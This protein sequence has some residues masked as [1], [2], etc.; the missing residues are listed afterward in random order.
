MFLYK[1]T[2]GNMGENAGNELE[3]NHFTQ[4][5]CVFKILLNGMLFVILVTCSQ[6]PFVAKFFREEEQSAVSSKSI[7]VRPAR[8]GVKPT[9]K[10]LRTSVGDKVSCLL[11]HCSLADT[12]SNSPQFAVCKKT[13]RLY[14]FTCVH[15]VG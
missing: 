1:C 5:E 4:Y 7:K 11:S 8:P 2:W 9:N 14:T 3:A 12:G 10:Q 15:F 13:L 6:F